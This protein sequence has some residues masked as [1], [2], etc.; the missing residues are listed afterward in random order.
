MTSLTELAALPLMA[1]GGTCELCGMEQD[2]L[3]GALCEPQLNKPVAK[4]V[5]NIH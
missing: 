3:K 4:F 1:L 2:Q 5:M